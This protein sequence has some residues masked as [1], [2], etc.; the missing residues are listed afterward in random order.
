MLRKG[1]YSYE[2]MHDWEKFNETSL[3]EKKYDFTDSDYMHAKRACEDFE[4]KKTYVNIMIC[5]LT[6]I[7]YF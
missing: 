5:I 2:Y 3:P 1:V 4:I 6:M 7:H